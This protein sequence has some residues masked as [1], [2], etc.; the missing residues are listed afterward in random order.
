[1]VADERR[2]SEMKRI[3]LCF[4]I[5]SAIRKPIHSQQQLRPQ[6]KDGGFYPPQ[7]SYGLNPRMASL[8]SGREGIWLFLDERV[9]GERMGSLRFPD[10]FLSQ[11]KV[12]L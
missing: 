1:M 6:F 7:L 4:S 5:V 12:K 8:N 10:L 11:F 2:P 3:L 9:Q